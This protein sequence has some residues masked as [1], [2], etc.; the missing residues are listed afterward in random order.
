MVRDHKIP[1]DTRLAGSS[2]LSVKSEFAETNNWWLT[3]G[4]S[5]EG[6]GRR[7]L[8]D[9]RASCGAGVRK[10]PKE[11]TAGR[12]GGRLIRALPMGILGSRTARVCRRGGWWR[13]ILAAGPTAAEV[14][15]REYARA[16]RERGGRRR[17]GDLVRT[18]ASCSGARRKARRSG[19]ARWEAQ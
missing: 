15:G 9:V 18:S 6:F 4:P 7:P 1:P 11:E 19:V 14:F 12:K 16:W 3:Y 17:T 5:Y 2:L 10:P 8:R 13:A